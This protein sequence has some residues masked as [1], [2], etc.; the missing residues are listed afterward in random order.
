MSAYKKGYRLTSDPWVIG[1]L[2][3]LGPGLLFYF[4]T[5]DY[6]VGATIASIGLAIAGFKVILAARLP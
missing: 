4:F 5:G 6:W 1:G 2:S 3:W